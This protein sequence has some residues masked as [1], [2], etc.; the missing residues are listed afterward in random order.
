M[1]SVALVTIGCKLN[2]FETEQMRESL[3]GLGYRIAN[4]RDVA[5]I[6]I[7]NTCTVTSK[8]DYRSRQ[9]IRRALR[10]NPDAL[11]IATGC[12]A[13]RFPDAIAKIEGVDVIIGNAEKHNIAEYVHIPKQSKPL[14]LSL[15]HI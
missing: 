1:K 9:A 4:Q 11:I 2:Q 15:I 5:D 3:E 14:I 7:I 13:Q 8:S 6:Y 10:A 12:Y